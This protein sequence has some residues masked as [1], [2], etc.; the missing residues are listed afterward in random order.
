[1][2]GAAPKTSRVTSHT[3]LL[4]K[5]TRPVCRSAGARMRISS[6]TMSPATTSTASPSTVSTAAHARSGTFARR[7]RTSGRGGALTMSLACSKY[8]LSSDR[9]LSQCRLDLLH[10]RSGQRRIVQRSGHLLSLVL[11]PPGE[12]EE[13]LAL[14]GVG[15]V[16]ID[17]KIGERRQGPRSLA[18]LVGDRDAVV[19]RHLHLGGRFGN[20]L[21]RPLDEAAV[22]GLQ[23]H[24]RHL[25][26]LGVREL[27]VA[28]VA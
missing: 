26:L 1:M 5:A 2:Y 4:T 16:A 18:G 19:V 28:D 27:S 7:G 17:Q 8:G 3:D 20:R 21:Q 10:H 25:V 13:R 22:V 6:A 24:H 15:L 12:L 14:R 9:H 23:L 11:G